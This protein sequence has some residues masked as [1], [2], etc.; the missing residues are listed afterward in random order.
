MRAASLAAFVV[1]AAVATL[2]PL[3]GAAS[4]AD[5]QQHCPA[6]A[7]TAARGSG[8]NTA[9]FRT[10]YAGQ[11]PGVPNGWEGQTIRAFSA[12]PRAATPPSTA[13]TR[14]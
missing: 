14:R 11:A 12:T 7:V 6:V 2:A 10:G 8:Q 5:A 13:R 1:A 4:D 3:S 9:I